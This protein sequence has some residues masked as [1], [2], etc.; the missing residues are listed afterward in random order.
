MPIRTRKQL[1]HPRAGGA[2]KRRG[3]RQVYETLRHK[4]LSLDLRPGASLDE[5][6]LV[7]MLGTSRTPVREA[8][9]RLGA[10]GLVVLLPNRG[11]HVAPLGLEQVR[12]FFEAVDVVQRTVNHW[13]ALRRRQE[14]LQEIR[15]GMLAFEKAAARRDADDMIEANRRFHEAIAGAG[16]NGYVGESYCR[17]LTEGLRLS[18]LLF[19]YDFAY[20][21][22]RSLARH[23]D[24]VILEHRQME[25]AIRDQDEGAADRL[26]GA[27]ARLA[28]ARLSHMMSAGLRQ[29]LEIPVYADPGPKRP[30]AVRRRRSSLRSA[31][32][33]GDALGAAGKAM[34]GIGD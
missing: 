34:G 20:D 33:R 11:A 18:R 29:G 1:A 9:I 26:G 17:L 3:S 31:D 24:Q 19:S 8:L 28:L 16:R 32:G 27:H 6:T 13:A 4:I 10:E 25:G 15:A 22:D 12:E 2:P 30:P 7:G 23:L 14:D 21:S 5:L